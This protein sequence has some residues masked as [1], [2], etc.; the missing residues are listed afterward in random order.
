MIPAGASVSAENGF[1][2]HLAE[3]RYTYDYVFEGTQGVQWLVLDYKGAG[4][5][6]ATFNAQVAAVKGAGSS[7]GGLRL[8]PGAAA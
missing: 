6:M 4:Y 8:R 1:P 5:D 7:T 3:R 2:S